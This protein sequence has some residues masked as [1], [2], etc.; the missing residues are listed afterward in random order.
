MK[1]PVLA[2]KDIKIGLF[3][4]PFV[5]RHAGEGIRDIEILYKNTQTKFGKNPTDFHL[6]QIATFD[7]STGEFHN[8]NPIVQLTNGALNGNPVQEL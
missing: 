6:Y 1:N 2:V 7:E 3:D 5:C 8:I 4:P